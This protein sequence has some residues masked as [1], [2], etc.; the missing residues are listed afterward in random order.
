[1]KEYLDSRAIKLI[2]ENSS[3]CSSFNNYSKI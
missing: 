1:M 2:G 3:K